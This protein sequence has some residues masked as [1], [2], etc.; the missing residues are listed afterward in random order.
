MAD[1]LES[2]GPIHMC[3]PLYPLCHTLYHTIDYRHKGLGPIDIKI[4]V[5]LFFQNGRRKRSP[6]FPVFDQVVGL[7]SCVRGRGG[8]YGSVP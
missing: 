2:G 8:Q 3:Y 7:V 1:R 5:Y 4:V 6:G